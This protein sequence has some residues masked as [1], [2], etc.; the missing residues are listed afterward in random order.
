MPIIGTFVRACYQ[1]LQAAPPFWL[2][3]G[4]CCCS[5]PISYEAGLCLR[6]ATEMPGESQAV[7]SVSVMEDIKKTAAEQVEAQDVVEEVQATAGLEAKQAVGTVLDLDTD[8]DWADVGRLET[9]EAEVAEWELVPQT[10]TS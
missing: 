5:L 9:T 8:N 6:E 3:V 4:L 10:E 7:V 1:S 2:V